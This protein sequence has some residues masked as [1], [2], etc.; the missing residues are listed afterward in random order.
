M[1]PM[2]QTHHSPT[3]AQ[4]LTPKTTE[5]L[6]SD[7]RNPQELNSSTTMVFLNS[8]LRSTD[9]FKISMLIITQKLC[10]YEFPNVVI[11]CTD[12][13]AHYHNTT[14]KNILISAFQYYC[15]LCN[16]MYFILNI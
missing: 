14:F 11:S 1:P 13:K 8:T 5:P 9:G 7:N 16:P 4:L 2:S 12:R 3:T 15:F 6:P 10:N